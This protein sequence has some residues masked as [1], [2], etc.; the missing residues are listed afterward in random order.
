M[1]ALKTVQSFYAALA[2]G[3][4]SGLVALLGPE[5]TWTEAEGFP[6]Y[7]GTWR[8]PQ[9]VVEKLLI[10][11]SRDWVGFSAT[12]LENVVDG[13]RVV[14]FGFYSGTAKATGRAMKAEF[15]HDWITRQGKIV[16]FRM[17]A[18]TA[19]VQAAMRHA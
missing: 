6:Y 8:S 4:V 16:S 17:Y 13:D 10:P 12:P 9:E 15:A 2:Q 3:D 1:S 5:L 11:L 14:T 19:L 18:D 7:S